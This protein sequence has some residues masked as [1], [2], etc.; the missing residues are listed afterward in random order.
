MHLSLLNDIKA[1]TTTMQ[2]CLVMC[3]EQYNLNNYVQE[4]HVLV[5]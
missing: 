5:V 4:L 1:E 2:I 3:K